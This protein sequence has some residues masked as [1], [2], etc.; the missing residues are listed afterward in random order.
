VAESKLRKERDSLQ[1]Q[2][3]WMWTSPDFWMKAVR[4]LT[5]DFSVERSY[6][7][8]V[9]ESLWSQLFCRA[10]LGKPIR[11]PRNRFSLHS[12]ISTFV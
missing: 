4:A 10:A 8:S 12:P 1:G 6:G 3:S 7:G 9:L 5:A 2:D 11:A